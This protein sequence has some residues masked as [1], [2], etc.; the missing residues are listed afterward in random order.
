MTNNFYE[1]VLRPIVEGEMNHVINYMRSVGLLK[2]VVKCPYCL[3]DMGTYP[4]K[5][6]CDLHAFR[7]MKRDCS[8]HKKYHSVR[9]GS[10]FEGTN[11]SLPLLLKVCFKWMCGHSQI[12]IL[13]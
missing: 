11:L 9:L 12:Q 5:R 4:Y 10:F 7:C 6:N 2:W 3:V 13:D 1:E 8:G